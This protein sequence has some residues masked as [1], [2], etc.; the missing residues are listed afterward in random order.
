M[1]GHVNNFSVTAGALVGACFGSL[2]GGRRRRNSH[3]LRALCATQRP[4][5]GMACLVGESPLH[6]HVDGP[7]AGKTSSPPMN[8]SSDG[9]ARLYK[10][11]QPKSGET[12]E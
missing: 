4:R 7:S 12:V 10:I 5:I 1:K 11:A 9:R 2:P 8:A 6:G 3:D